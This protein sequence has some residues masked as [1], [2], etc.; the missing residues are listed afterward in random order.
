MG[1]IPYKINAGKQKPAWEKTKPRRKNIAIVTGA[2]SGFGREFVKILN[3][4]EELD[5]IWAIARDRGKLAKLQQRFGEKIKIYPVDLSDL[6]AVLEFEKVVE[7]K[8]PNIRYL[9]NNAGYAKFCSSC[10]MPVR[11]TMNMINLNCGAVAVMSLVALP[12]MGR[13]SHILNVSSMASFQPLPY[14]NLYSASKVFVRHYSRA[15]HVELKHRGISVTAVCPGWMRTALYQRA[16]VGSE[17]TVN[18]FFGITA[19]DKVARKA[20]KDAKKNRPMS[21]YG[22]YP[23]TA[24]AAAKALPQT[25]IMKLWMRQQGF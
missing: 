1:L 18:N 4:E 8:Q 24:H 25:V 6:D 20:F 14:L 15:M 17:K 2:S 5:E 16:R 22:I 21:V 9:I 12:Y 13:G 10:Q 19:P 11:E 3:K 23:K 7:Q